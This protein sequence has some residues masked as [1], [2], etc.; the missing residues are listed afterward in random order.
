MQVLRVMNLGV[1]QLGG[2]VSESAK[3][4]KLGC[5]PGLFPSEGLTGAGV[6]G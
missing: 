1:A 3:R 5:W 4:V 6:S 2:I